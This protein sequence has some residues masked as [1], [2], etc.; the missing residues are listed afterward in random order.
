[1]KI[2]RRVR[3][4]HRLEQQ[5]INRRT[6]GPRKR[7]ERARRDARMRAQLQQATDGRYSPALASWIAAKLGRPARQATPEQIKQ[8]LAV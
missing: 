5:G 7:A 2:R 3:L 6:N 1:V 4:D 8:L